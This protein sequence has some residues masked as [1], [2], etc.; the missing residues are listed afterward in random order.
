MWSHIEKHKVKYYWASA[1]LGAFGTEAKLFFLCQPSRRI[2]G[3][4]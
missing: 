4:D 1:I 3:F 2:G